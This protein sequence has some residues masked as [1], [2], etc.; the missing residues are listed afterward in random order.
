[1][2]PA[3]AVDGG[4]YAA[5]NVARHGVYCV[6]MCLALAGCRGSEA[7][8]ATSPVK[9]VSITL[10]STQIM[11]GNTTRA[12]AVLRDAEGNIISDRLPRWTSLTPAITAIAADGLITGLQAGTGQVR[13]ASGIVVADATVIVRNPLAGRFTLARDTATL[14]FPSGT[15]QA[16]AVVTDEV[17]QPITNPNITWTSSNP[18]VAAVNVV[19]LVTAVASGSAIISG[20]IDG[21]AATLTVTVRPVPSAFAPTISTV[22]PPILRPGGAYTLT[23][24]RFGVSPGA[25]QVRIEGMA[26][27]VQSASSTQ[28]TIVLPTVGFTCEPSRDAFLQVSAGPFAGGTTAPL[29]VGTKRTMAVG[30]SV[31]VTAGPEVRCNELVPAN[32]RWVVSIYNATRATVSPAQPAGVQFAIRGL[33]IAAGALPNA[34]RVEPPL[35]MLRTA[36]GGQMAGRVESNGVQAATHEQILDRNIAASVGAAWLSRAPS[37]TVRPAHLITTLGKITTVKLP[38]L[39]ASDFCVSNIPIGARTAFVGAHSLI[40]EDTTS[41]FDGRQTLKGQMDD[42]FTRLGR[43]FESL[44]WPMLNATVGNPLAMDAQLGGPGKVVMVFSPRVNAM[45]RGGVVGFVSSCDLFSVAQRPSSNTGAFFYAMVPTSTASGY[46]NSETRDQWLR[47]LR[48][49]VI[50]EVR[51]VTS[52]AERAARGLAFEDASWEEGGAR[53]AEEMYARAIY[54]TQRRA[55]VTYAQSLACDIRYLERSLA[56]ADRPLMM[57]RHFDGLYAYLA[58]PEIYSPLGRTFS[59]EVAFYAGAWSMLR[60]AS[61]HAGVTEAQFFRDFTISTVT[62]SANM[63]ARTGRAWEESLGEWSLAMYLDDLAGFSPQSERVKLA[64]WN[65]ANLWAGMCADMGPCE[66][67]ANPVQIYGRSSPFFPKARSFGNFLLGVGTMAG[68]GFTILD[69]SGT[70]AASQVIELKSLIGSADPPAT[71]RLA[72]A[73]VR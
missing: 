51:H 54:G 67:P 3:L 37:R 63:E 31:V 62:G 50:H 66:N 18:L 12:T 36:G 49:T 17:G 61:D 13:A 53:I 21:L 33:T 9:S 38:N 30:Q 48:A 26:A 68:G 39:D 71:L 7:P 20:S 16:I 2:R 43:E 24:L 69:L 35:E 47:L 15:V 14:A 64:S 42:Y 44:M 52:F 8:T 45:Q 73:R 46:T 4:R 32:G 60:W 10:L 55:N 40:L 25:N 59:G 57:L 6:T 56:C 22:S 19:G 34:P 72:I 1:M 58:S 29:E 27:T 65:L 70:G 41:S 5:R 11:V 23:G 28:L